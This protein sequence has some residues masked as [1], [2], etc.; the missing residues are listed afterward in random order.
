MKSVSSSIK[1]SKNKQ[2]LDVGKYVMENIWK[3]SMN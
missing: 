1:L 3:I 2:M